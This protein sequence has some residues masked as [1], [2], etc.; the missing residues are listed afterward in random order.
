MHKAPRHN[1]SRA[2]RIEYCAVVTIHIAP[3]PV[4]PAALALP[5]PLWHLLPSHCTALA[6]KFPLWH[7]LP[8]PLW[9]LLP[10][11][12]WHLL[13]SPLWHLLPS[14]L[15]HLLPAPP[16]APAALAPVAPTALAL[17]LP[18][19]HLMPSQ[20]CA[21]PRWCTIGFS[22]SLLHGQRSAARQL[23]ASKRRVDQKGAGAILRIF[24][25]PH[26]PICVTDVCIPRTFTHTYPHPPAL[27]TQPGH[28]YST[29]CAGTGAESLCW[30]KRCAV[31]ST[32]ICLICGRI[33]LRG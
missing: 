32:S 25:S 20:T 17:H 30:S 16:L 13:P 22:T 24:R 14:P 29:G 18:L 23:A 7:L 12:L 6:L 8:S 21:K 10:S 5:L 15:W 9:H 26:H 11:P 4:A 31:A 3:A 28:S 27:P 33:Y 1:Y 2:K 19:W